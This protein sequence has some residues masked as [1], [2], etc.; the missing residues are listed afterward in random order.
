MPVVT[1]NVKCMSWSRSTS[2]GY[3]GHA[4]RQMDAHGCPERQMDAH[5]CPERQLSVQGVRQRLLDAHGGPQSLRL[6]CLLVHRLRDAR[7]DVAGR[8]RDAMGARV[9]QTALHAQSGGVALG[10]G[11]GAKVEL[12]QRGLG[13]GTLGVAAVL[14]EVS[15]LFTGGAMDLCDTVSYT[16]LTLPTSS[17]V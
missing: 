5:G 11:R 9:L 13:R 12:A 4:P 3:H 17:Y 7:A 15:R 8:V 6:H 2:N 14:R 16:H 1:L 10:I